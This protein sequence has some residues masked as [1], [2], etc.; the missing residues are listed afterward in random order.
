MKNFSNGHVVI[1]SDAM[2]QKNNKP[3]FG[4]IGVI[5][6]E[7]KAYNEINVNVFNEVLPFAKTELIH[8]NYFIGRKVMKKSG[9]PFKSQLQMNTVNSVTINENTNNPAFTFVEDSSVVDCHI[10]DYS[11]YVTK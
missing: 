7:N 10:I 3:L 11:D 6:S 1:V 9:K 4:K 8:C 2:S 5:V